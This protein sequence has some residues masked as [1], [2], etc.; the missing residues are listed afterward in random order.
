[1]IWTRKFLT[2]ISA[3]FNK[4]PLTPL[5]ETLR[6]PITSNE[7]FSL[8]KE[9]YGISFKNPLIIYNGYFYFR[10]Y[11]DYFFQLLIQPRTCLICWRLLREIKKAKI[12]WEQ[13]VEIFLNEFDQLK[14]KDLSAL[15]NSELFKHIQETIKFDACW[16][17][18]LGF[19]LPIIYHYLLETILNFLYRLLV[20][21][22]NTQNYHELLAGYPNKREEADLAFWEV[23]KGDLTLDDYLEKYGLRA[24]D[25]SLIV[26]TIGENREDMQMR[27]DAFRNISLLDFEEIREK[28]LKTRNL[29]EE[30][31]SKNFRFWVPFGKKIFNNILRTTREY[32]PIRETRRFYYT[33][34]SYLIRKAVLLLGERF[35]FLEKSDDI[36]FLT[37]DEIE[38]EV[39]QP[40][41]IDKEKIKG[42]I[43]KRRKQW[44][45]RSEHTPLEQIKL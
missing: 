34:G 32:A 8:I 3:W 2:K 41:T 25:A 4:K 28:L 1:M 38:R 22:K 27:V 30:Y 36:F 43:I 31:V 16:M 17:F 42:E 6:F 24:T 9:E 13:N 33:K 23:V 20:K 5:D 45:E 21:D 35:K 7:F 12:C 44:Q 18:K 40:G 11:K 29:R 37:K 39:L 14:H 26:P 19:G 15:S 10:S